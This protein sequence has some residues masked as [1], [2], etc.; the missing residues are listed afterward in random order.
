M[1][2]PRVARSVR[3]S[4][5]AIRMTSVLRSAPAAPML[6]S[7]TIQAT[8]SPL[9]DQQA[10]KYPLGPA[11][12][13]SRRSHGDRDLVIAMYRRWLLQRPG[14]M[15][16]LPELR[17][18]DLVCWCAPEECHGDVLIE[19]ANTHDSAHAANSTNSACQ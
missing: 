10:G 18:K 5:R 9:T 7:F 8:L 1:L 14:L 16:A 11:P 3:S 13:I 4:G 19:L 15:A 12:P 6:T 2:R 17:G